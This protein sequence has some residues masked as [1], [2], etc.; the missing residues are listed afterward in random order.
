MRV[1]RVILSADNPLFQRAYPVLM[2]LFCQ[3]V[4]STS[5]KQLMLG[6]G[7][8]I[9]TS[10]AG[11]PV[12]IFRRLIH[13]GIVV[14]L[15]WFL[16]KEVSALGV[17]PEVVLIVALMA[18]LYKEL[19]REVSELLLY[20]LILVTG[21]GFLRWMCKGYLSGSGFRQL[22]MTRWPMES[23]VGVMVNAID[24][25]YR[26]QYE[27]LMELYLESNDPDCEAKLETALATYEDAK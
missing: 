21:G 5:S 2:K 19:Y 16:R 15:W 7:L 3:G 6:A 13:V 20:L 8:S 1:S 11:W 17:A 25:E 9:L 24:R 27:Y 18:V 10:P 23:V 22:A 12:A 4:Q 26:R 14:G